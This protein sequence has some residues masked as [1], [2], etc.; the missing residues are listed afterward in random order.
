MN[1]RTRGILI[2]I[3]ATFCWGMMVIP[4]RR[5][6]DYGAGLGSLDIAFLRMGLTTAMLFIILLIVDRKSLKIRLKDLWI[7][8]IFGF[9]E[10]L[11]E[12]FIFY[13]MN[14]ISSS[15]ATLLQMTSPYYI[16]LMAYFFFGE[17]ITK[18]M[19]VASIIAIGGCIMATGVIL[20]VDNINILGILAGIGSGMAYAAFVIGS[21]LS[22]DRSY[23]PQ[24][25][26][27]YT[28]LFG[29]LFAVPLVNFGKIASVTFSG[30][31]SIPTHMI[32]L[33]FFMTLIP[34]YLSNVAIRDIGASLTSIIELLEIAF[35]AF[36]EFFAFGVGIGPLKLIGMMLIVVAML[37]FDEE[38]SNYIKEKFR[39]LT[40]RFAKQSD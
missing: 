40:G 20:G 32:L 10:L 35:S 14:N 37:V 29:A 27:F 30:D 22:M 18:R 15:L 23:T 36:A 7:F 6:G 21:R 12:I 38:S 11:A 1:K 31:I 34:Y 26:L 5:L 16:M 2:T 33:S 3:L 39:K 17:K 4:V 24:G 25:T 8:L 19:A 9:M 13:A 28:F